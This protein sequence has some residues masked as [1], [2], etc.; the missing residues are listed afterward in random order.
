M[1]NNLVAV[2][3]NF[4]KG[5]YR[6]ASHD[7]L[8]VYAVVNESSPL[9]NKYDWHN[10]LGWCDFEDQDEESMAYHQALDDFFWSS[11]TEITF[12]STLRTGEFAYG[13]IVYNVNTILQARELTEALIKWLY[14]ETLKISSPT[15]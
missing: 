6:W 3:T 5:Y 14:D 12:S 7:T 13:S 10:F 2:L 9:Y 15:T 4:G 8:C 11:P 1:N